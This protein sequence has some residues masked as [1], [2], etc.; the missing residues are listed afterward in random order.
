MKNA[1]SA[2]LGLMVALYAGAALAYTLACKDSACDVKCDNGQFIGTM[3]WNGSQWS[4]GVRADPDKDVVAR[5]MVAAWG[6]SCT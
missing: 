2:V 6:T 4:D 5:L 1:V 3:Y